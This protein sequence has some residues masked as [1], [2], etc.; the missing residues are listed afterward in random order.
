MFADKVYFEKINNKKIFC[1]SSEPKPSQKKIVIM[2]HGFRGSSI[3]PAR[4]FVNFAKILNQKGISSLRF[5]QPNSGNSEGDYLN[6]SFNEWV[7]TTMYF[8]KN[9]S[10]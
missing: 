10:I 2:N 8:A 6:S 7:N 3:G 9:I 5:D 4:T 1:V